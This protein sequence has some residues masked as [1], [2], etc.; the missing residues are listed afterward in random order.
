MFA[1]TGWQHPALF[2]DSDLEGRGES[3]ISELPYTWLSLSKVLI[4]LP[5]A[6]LE[7]SALFFLFI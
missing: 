7:A 1:G 6:F 3:G 5:L 2:A 4:H